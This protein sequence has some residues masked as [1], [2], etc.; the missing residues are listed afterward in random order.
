MPL[1]AYARTTACPPGRW[2]GRRRPRRHRRPRP[3]RWCLPPRGPRHACSGT[4]WEEFA[5]LTGPVPWVRL[6]RTSRSGW[7]WSAYQGN[8]VSR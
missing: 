5:R 1:P 8:R 6:A 3:V 7:S 4:L 2:R